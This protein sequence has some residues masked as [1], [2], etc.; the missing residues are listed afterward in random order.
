MTRITQTGDGV[1][2]KRVDFDYDGAS[3]LKRINRY[4]DLSGTQLVAISTT[5]FDLA[6]RLTELTYNNDSGVI[7]GYEFG[8]TGRELDEETGLTYYCPRYYDAPT[9]S[10][11]LDPHL[12]NARSILLPSMDSWNF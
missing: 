7:H 1:T 10:S 2:D 8:Y 6:G 9:T 4:A 11:L 3:Q 5:K 12:I